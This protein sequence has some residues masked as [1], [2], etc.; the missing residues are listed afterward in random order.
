MKK[1]KLKL[2]ELKLTSFTTDDALFKAMRTMKGGKTTVI[3]ISDQCDYTASDFM[4]LETNNEVCPT[5]Y[6][7]PNCHYK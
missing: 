2:T 7:Y 3:K 1:Q 4:C 6:P 5:V